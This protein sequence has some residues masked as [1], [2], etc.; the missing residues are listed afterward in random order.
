MINDKIS[1]DI[2]MK[3]RT[4]FIGIL[5]FFSF[6]SVA[7]GGGK[8]ITPY[9]D[10]CGACITYGVCK[11]VLPTNAA[12]KALNKYY[13]EKGYRVGAVQLK[14]RFM[15]AEIYMDDIKVDKVLFDRKT[16]RLRSIY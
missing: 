9:G 10:Y 7:N 8:W 3:F 15:E 2:L 13:G 16:G 5:L 12:M 11:D 4:A 6:A 1:K 14:G